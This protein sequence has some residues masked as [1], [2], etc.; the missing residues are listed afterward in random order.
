MIE[1]VTGAVSLPFYDGAACAKSVPKDVTV[2]TYC[3]CPHNES[4]HLAESLKKAG[5]AKVKVMDEGFIH[6]KSE[7][8]PVT[9]GPNHPSRKKK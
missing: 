3:A 8:H 7:G 5:L 1:H 6:W 4:V 9:K 2:I